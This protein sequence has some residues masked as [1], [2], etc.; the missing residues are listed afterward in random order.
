[1]GRTI[2]CFF[3]NPNLGVEDGLDFSYEE[4]GNGITLKKPIFTIDVLEKIIAGIKKA[5]QDCLLNHD[6]PAVLDAID[7]VNALWMDSG[8]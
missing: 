5:R 7:K 4:V 1:M 3:W 2:D 8:Y 6:I